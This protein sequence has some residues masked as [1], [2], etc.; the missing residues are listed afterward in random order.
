MVPRENKYSAYVKLWKVKKWYYGTFE[1]GLLE[2]LKDYVTCYIVNNYMR[3]LL[4]R[5]K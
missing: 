2:N 3:C 5:N 1:S 4:K